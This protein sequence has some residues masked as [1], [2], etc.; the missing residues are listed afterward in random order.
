M[1]D[2]IIKRTGDLLRRSIIEHNVSQVEFANKIIDDAIGYFDRSTDHEAVRTQLK[3][4]FATGI[5][6]QAGIDDT[7]TDAG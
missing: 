3:Q 1:I 7:D 4:R 6:K 5:T 2:G